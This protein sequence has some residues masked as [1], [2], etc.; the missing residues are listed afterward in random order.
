MKR[1]ERIAQRSTSAA[2]SPTKGVQCS[3]S[4]TEVTATFQATK[5]NPDGESSSEDW[6]EECDHV[7]GAFPVDGP[8]AQG[9]NMHIGCEENSTNLAADTVLAGYCVSDEDLHKEEWMVHRIA[10]LE[11]ERD[12]YNR[13]QQEQ[14][15]NR[16][17]D[18]NPGKKRRG[19][20]E[21]IPRGGKLLV[22]VFASI[23]SMVV[24]SSLAIFFL[25]SNN[26]TSPAK[27]EQ[28]KE[29]PNTLSPTSTTHN[30]FDQ[31][32]GILSS[33]N[34]TPVG[35]IDD[36]SSPQYKAIEWITIDD[37]YTKSSFLNLTNKKY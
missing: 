29:E 37:T 8:N 11:Q 27:A 26:D 35:T 3:F 21:R 36:P 7:P 12:E 16:V 20:S 28:E 10:E 17:V 9:D 30:A 22:V 25:K 1:Q 15:R 34:A 6:D 5:A 23:I 32:M 4:S 24:A 13:Q 18:A 2:A 31:V 14:H 33:V 19:S